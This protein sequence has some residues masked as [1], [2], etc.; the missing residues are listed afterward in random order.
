MNKAVIALL[1]A[2]AFVLS[3]AGIAGGTTRVPGAN[4]DAN[5]ITG[6]YVSGN[7]GYGT[8]DIKLPKDLPSGISASHSGFAWSGALGYQFNQ[9]IALEGGYIQF[10]N[11]EVK[12]DS[13]GNVK[14]H[15]NA[16]DLALKGIYPINQRFD[17]FGKA[18]LAYMSHSVAG[19]ANGGSTVTVSIKNHQIA[20]LFGLGAAYNITRKVAVDVQGIT[21]LKS[22]DDG[23]YPATYTGL[24][25]LTY[26]FG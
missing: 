8:V 4:T 13:V 12:Q 16:V 14:L 11:V 17:V 26:K 18:G 7:L 15:T 5:N 20:P 21:T 6:L 24:V 25:G 9:Y 23:E 3:T 10:A 2:S 19:T 22:G 1:G